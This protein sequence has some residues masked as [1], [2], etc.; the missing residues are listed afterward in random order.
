MARQDALL[1]LHQ[2]LVAQRDELRKKLALQSSALR[3]A[4]EPG[5]SGDI[6]NFDAELEVESQLASLESR[7]LVRIEKAIQ[8]IKDGTYGR[9]EYCSER[10]PVAR[11]NALPHTSCCVRCQEKMETRRHR[12]AQELDWASAWEYQVRE[13]DRELTPQDVRFESD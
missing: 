4:S 6:I 13:A 10:I 11:L 3:T 2:R 7:E 9:C 12:K 8:S 5:D 1:R